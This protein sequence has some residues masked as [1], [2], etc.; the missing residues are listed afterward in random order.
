[1]ANRYFVAT[2]PAPG[3]A[4]VDGELAHHL[5]RVL[6]VRPGDAVRLGDGNGH[7]ATA[8]VVAAG[9]G[10]VALH[11]EPA[12]FEPRPPLAV[13]LAFAVP[14]HTRTEWLLEHGTE[15][16]VATFQPL[17]TERTRPQGERTGRWE[18]IVH[19]AAGQ[20]D[21]AWLP[22]LAPACELADFLASPELPAARLLASGT[23]PRGFAGMPAAGAV[24]LLVGPEGG[25]TDGE[26]ERI[27]AAQFA[28]LRL[29]PHVLRTE[30]AALVGA[31]LLLAQ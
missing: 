23:G 3:P 13:T 11:V 27:A 1:M 4:T 15:V 31:A 26:L 20:S 18:R 30:T 12:E 9:R 24:A 8:R 14:R 25:F 2:L 19:A 28:P 10:E 5:G 22:T 6:R 17:W 21:R 29:G 16:G 7:T